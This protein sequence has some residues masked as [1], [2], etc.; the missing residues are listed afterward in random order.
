MSRSFSRPAS[1]RV[2]SVAN[3][4]MVLARRRALLRP[5]LVA[6]A[7]VAL[8]AC[9]TVRPDQVG[10]K[11]TFGR[12]SSG[13]LNPGAQFV[14]PG[15]NSVIRMPARTVNRE[16]RLEL[17][18]RE[19]LNVAADVS[20]LYR[21]RPEMAAKILETGGRAYEDDVVIPVFRSAA[22][23]VAARFMAKD[24]YGGERAAIEKAIQAQMAQG[25]AA[26]GFVV[27]QVLLKSIR[28]PADLA[29]AVEEKLEAEQRAEQMQFV[30]QREKAEAERKR[31]EAEGVRQAQDI[32]AGSLTPMIISFRSI[33][34]FRELARSPNAKV[35][36]TDGRTPYLIGPE[37]AAT[38]TSAAEQASARP[39]ARQ[40]PQRGVVRAADAR[41]Q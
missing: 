2:P 10:V 24:M 40:A 27:E 33:E 8:G 5:A 14:V 31:I 32:I 13:T 41:R 25:L 7:A 1:R 15:V 36:V 28:L 11:T 35:I 4:V 38:A 26:R 21:I 17:P 9:A 20:I 6:G 3:R 34:A 23:D 29:Q 22:A 39:D 18:S 16:V 30:L 12:I 37:G 19:G